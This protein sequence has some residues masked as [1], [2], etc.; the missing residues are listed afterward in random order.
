MKQLLL[1]VVVG[2]ASALELTRLVKTDN[3]LVGMVGSVWDEVVSNHDFGL[4]DPKLP[5]A[6]SKAALSKEEALYHYS[7]SQAGVVDSARFLITFGIATELAELQSSPL[8]QAIV[9]N[10]LTEVESV[11]S[12]FGQ[13]YV[14][15]QFPLHMLAAIHDQHNRQP[16]VE[17]LIREMDYLNVE[18][19]PNHGATPLMV[20]ACLGNVDMI[21]SLVQV[22]GANVNA[23]HSYAGTSALHFAAEMGHVQAMQ[24]LVDLGA[25]VELANNLGGTA[26]HTAADSNRAHAVEWLLTQVKANPNALLNWDT[27]PL[28]LASQ[29]GYVQVVQALLKCPQTLIDFTMPMGKGKTMSQGLSTSNGEQPADRYNAGE[30]NAELGNG[31]TAL[32][33]AAEN[34]H[35]DCVME[36][37]RHG[38]KQLNS[39]R[40]STPL[41]IALQYRHVDIALELMRHEDH[42]CNVQSPLDGAFPLFV[43][44]GNGYLHAVHELVLGL[45]C[46]VDLRNKHGASALSHALYRNHFSLAQWLITKAGAK[47]DLIALQAAAV[48]VDLPD[49]G[50]DYV[51][52]QYSGDVFPDFPLNRAQLMS[53]WRHGRVDP[54]QHEFFVNAQLGNVQWIAWVMEIWGRDHVDNVK[55][56]MAGYRVTALYLASENNHTGVVQALLAGGANATK[57]LFMF[58][59]GEITPLQVAVEHGYLG[60]VQLLAGELAPSVLGEQLTKLLIAHVQEQTPLQT[61]MLAL[62]AVPGWTSYESPFTAMH[63]ATIAYWEDGE[64]G[65]TKAVALLRLL[66]LGTGQN[67]LGKRTIGTRLT[68]LGLGIESNRPQVVKLLLNFARAESWE[69]VNAKG[70]TLVQQANRVGLPVAAVIQAWQSPPQVRPLRKPAREELPEL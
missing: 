46:T 68:P 49:A 23:K 9:R 20:A 10:N 62:L 60:V 8:Y 57:G 66:L 24:R 64:D 67:L 28:Y 53:L 26:L 56:M 4:G 13:A 14:G 34:G 1:L 36:L 59:K 45:G 70:E 63:A 44:A 31:A 58:E 39:M 21:T 42:Q 37:K 48:A 11:F 32:H 19:S 40:G 7:A 27:T 51:A 17:L 35:L 6:A 22:C 30:K 18:I 47:V 33:V 61:E 52:S 50:F 38:A 55:E 2:L 41:L 54:F 12:E 43:A 65:E 3:N 15:N 5:L 29:R 25:N 16:I 69:E